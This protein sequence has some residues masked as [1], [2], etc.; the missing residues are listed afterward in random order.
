MEGGGGREGGREGGKGEG[1][2][3]EG[4][5]KIQAD[6]VNIISLQTIMKNIKKSNIWHG[7]PWVDSLHLL[8]LPPSLGRV[9]QTLVYRSHHCDPSPVLVGWGLERRT[10]CRRRYW[11]FLRTCPLWS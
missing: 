6:S 11:L 5:E 3:G 2:K 10:Q 8:S 4:G 7:P 1:G 9:T